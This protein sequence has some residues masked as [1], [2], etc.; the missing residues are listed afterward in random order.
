MSTAVLK[1]VVR[2]MAPRSRYDGRVVFLH[3]AK[4]AGTSTEAAIG[5]ALGRPRRFYLDPFASKAAADAMGQ[6]MEAFRQHILLYALAH[7]NVDF[8]A[9]HL[10]W[11][12]HAEGAK[13]PG[14][15]FLTVLRHPYARLLS[16][17]HFSRYRGGDRGHLAHEQD[18]HEWLDWREREVLIPDFVRFFSGH[19]TDELIAEAGSVEAARRLGAERAIAVLRRLDIVGEITRL[20]EVEARFREM[21]GLTLRHP[22]KRR[23]PV[24]YAPFEEQP[25]DVRR[26]VERHLAGDMEVYAAAFP[27]RV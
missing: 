27:A 18:L 25:R 19:T 1:A 21:T 17:Y 24:T 8:I 26:I 13:R 20:P 14:D 9:G 15:L 3:L 11:S 10:P 4:A 5:A 7:R 22:Q 6:S 12:R 23:S 16:L 2:R